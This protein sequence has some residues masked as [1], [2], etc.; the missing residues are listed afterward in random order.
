MFMVCRPERSRKRPQGVTA[1][2]KDPDNFPS[3]R[4]VKA[5]SKM[6]PPL[7]LKGS[8]LSKAATHLEIAT[9]WFLLIA[10]G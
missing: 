1:K 5:F 7:S 4:L 3:P 2:S 6:Q 8:P 9:I 10:N